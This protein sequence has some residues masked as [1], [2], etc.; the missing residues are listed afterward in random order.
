MRMM[1]TVC[2]HEKSVKKCLFPNA[3]HIN[4]NRFFYLYKS[5]VFH[6]P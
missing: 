6:F 1:N 5:L 2:G 3:L 4:L